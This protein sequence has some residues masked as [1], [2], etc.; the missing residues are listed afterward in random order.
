MTTSFRA[1]TFATLALTFVLTACGGGGG[2]GGTP[3]GSAPQSVT[4]TETNAKPVSAN[5]L[6][7]AQTTSATS[8]ATGPIGVQVDA[9]ANAGVSTLQAMA[10]VARLAAAKSL[11]GSSLPTG[12]V[13]NPTT[14][15][16]DFGGTTTVSGNIASSSGLA[17]GDSLSVSMSN[18]GVSIGG[19]MAV[20]NG[21]MT[22]NVVSGSLP[23]FST[24]S[25]HIVLAVTTTNLSL[26]TGGVTV[27][28]T[29]DTRLD[30][31]AAS[32]TSQTLVA[33]GAS[34][35]SRTTTSGVTHTTT[36]RNYTQSV[37]ISGST[38]TGTLAATVETDSSHIGAG[39]VTY[40]VSTP[41]P[42]V[43]NVATRVASSGVVKVVGANN[44]A[45]LVTIAAGGAV[46]IQIDA[47][48]DGTYEKTITS[49]VAELAGLV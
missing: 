4:I 10:E 47:N 31:T 5:A 45:L 34:M 32:A 29:G 8:G 9:G 38:Y 22:L 13:I 39:T 20:M 48:G 41:T 6:E 1:C 17:A 28:S 42:V 36:L 43:W 2:G 40:T 16:C 37:T 15:S 30:W 49:T 35:S 18:C 11:G 19:T 21:A 27:V 12:V 23:L 25:F 44:A 3:G 7:A 14:E 33:S 24:G 46:T 26:A